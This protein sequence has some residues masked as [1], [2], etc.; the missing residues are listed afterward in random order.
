MM[1]Y[2]YFLRHL[3]LPNALVV[4]LHRDFKNGVARKLNI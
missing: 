3:S 1:N 2:S 4:K